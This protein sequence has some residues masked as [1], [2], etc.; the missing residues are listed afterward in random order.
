MVKV[1]Y[2]GV[3]TNVSNPSGL[4]N[5]SGI[6]ASGPS[7][8]TF[9]GITSYDT[10]LIPSLGSAGGVGIRAFYNPVTVVVTIDGLYDF[11][12]GGTFIIDDFP[13]GSGPN[14]F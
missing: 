8:S 14:R 5:G 13:A 11:S 10:T 4:L 1:E 2:S 9:T 12:L 6:T 7:P 3:I